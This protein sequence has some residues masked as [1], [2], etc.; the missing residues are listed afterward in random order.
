VVLFLMHCFSNALLL[1]VCF[2]FIVPI[3]LVSMILTDN[4]ICICWAWA[5]TWFDDMTPWPICREGRTRKGIIQL[6]SPIRPRTMSV[7]PDSER[8]VVTLMIRVNINKVKPQKQAACYHWKNG[9]IW[10]P[11]QGSLYFLI[12]ALRTYEWRKAVTAYSY[13]IFY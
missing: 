3:W 2:I 13:Y 6:V 11:R 4:W 5:W 7:N 8:L 12:L 1:A 10:L 9:G